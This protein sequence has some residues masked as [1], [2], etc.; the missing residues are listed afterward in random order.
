MVE[1][2][3]EEKARALQNVEKMLLKL[4]ALEK[5]LEVSNAKLTYIVT[6][7]GTPGIC[8]QVRRNTA[9]IAEAKASAKYWIGGTFFLVVGQY[10][11]YIFERFSQ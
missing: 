2:S 10:L 11:K 4:E 5:S 8:E 3:E 6:G 1:Y 9:D 7:N